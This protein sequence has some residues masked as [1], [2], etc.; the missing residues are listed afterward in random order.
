MGVKLTLEPWVISDFGYD[1]YI[2]II[3]STKQNLLYLSK[4]NSLHGDGTFDASPHLFYQ[5]YSIHATYLGRIVPLFFCLLPTKLKRHVKAF[6]GIKDNL[7]KFDFL[8]DTLS[9]LK[10]ILAN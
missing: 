2:L 7:R 10:P 6:Q 5:L 9:T 1:E 8:E 3:F 4:S